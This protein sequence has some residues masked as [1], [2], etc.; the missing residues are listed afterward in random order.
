MGDIEDLSKKLQDSLNEK[1]RKNSED[2]EN[3]IL[4]K[5]NWNVIIN[6]TIDIYKNLG[7]TNE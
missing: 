7:G 2:I 6:K 1:N 5:Y 4:K 3:Y